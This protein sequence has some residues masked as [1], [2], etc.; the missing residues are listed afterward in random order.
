MEWVSSCWKRNDT[1]AFLLKNTLALWF[2]IAALFAGQP[3]AAQNPAADFHF[4]N[5]TTLQGLSSNDITCLYQDRK[6]FLWVGTHFGL[7]RYD[8]NLFKTFY[9]EVDNSNSLSGNDVS[10]ILEDRD[11]IFWI[12]TKDGGLTRYDPSANPGKQFMQFQNN[13]R[14]A[15]SLAVNRLT[16]LCDYSE[17]YL[18]IGAETVPAIF[19]NKKTFGLTYAP[20]S[21]IE[22]GY[23]NPSH[24]RENPS[25]PIN[26]IHHIESTDSSIYI[27]FLIGGYVY[28]I[29][30]A[31]GKFNIPAVVFKASPAFSIP[32]FLVDGQKIWLAA[33]RKG[34]FVQDGPLSDTLHIPVQRK[35]MNVEDEILCLADW[36]SEYVVAGSKSSGLYLV[37]RQDY[38]LVNLHHERSDLF[39]IASNRVNCLLRD[40][41]GILWV[42]TSDGLSKYDPEQWQLHSQ[43]LLPDDGKDLVHFSMYEDESGTLRLCSS[44]GVF[45]FR[46]GEEVPELIPFEEKGED[47]SPA[48]IF[49]SDNGTYYLGSETRMF[50][51][52]PGS[53]SISPIE[54]K[55]LDG[56]PPGGY[57][58]IN[59]QVRSILSDT[60]DGHPFLI[61]GILGDGLGLYDLEQKQ[62]KLMVKSEVNP[63]SIGN[64]LI[65]A[66]T[67]DHDGTIWVGT[68]NGL[69]RWRKSFPLQNDFDSFLHEPGND[70]TI[71]GNE[72]T[73]LWVD[74]QNHLWITTNGNGLNEFDGTIFRHYHTTSIMGNKMSDLVEDGQ[75]RLWIA[76]SSGFAVFTKE[77]K[78]FDEIPL[79]NSEWILK[80]PARMLRRKDGTVVYGAGNYLISFRPDS[81]RISHAR[82]QIYLTGFTVMGQEM[83]AESP[84]Q[85]LTFPFNRNF[86]TFRFSA[87]Q[88]SQP[89]TV[90][91]QYWLKGLEDNWVDAA[92]NGQVAFTSLPPGTFD[93]F[94][95]ATDPTGSWGPP[96]SLATFRIMTP[97]WLTWWFI[98][99]CVIA[100][101]ALVLIITRIRVQQLLRLQT[102][103]QKIAADL[104]DDIGSA[105]SSISISSQLVKKF[106]THEDEKVDRILNRIN[107]TSKETLESMSDIVWAINPKNDGGGSMMMK[108]QRVAADLLESKGIEVEFRCDREFE[109]MKLGMEARKNIFLIYKEAIN[110]ISRHSGCSKVCIR[111]HV[112]DQHFHL[113][114]EDDG[115]GFVFTKSALGNGLDSMQRRAAML[116]ESLVI[117]SEVGRGT[118]IELKIPSTKIRD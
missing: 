6:G 59:L 63:G 56:A 71:S 94:V 29:D 69:Y 18:L 36:S 41:Q 85:E 45:R 49:R 92:T 87:L 117:H 38:S 114:L 103:R 118:R 42:G 77:T 74:N 79:A 80:A 78:K 20:V 35:V 46:R 81:F 110:N 37:N 115:K 28:S 31:T 97:F 105:L 39:S 44:A 15:G 8:G 14:K 112:S 109:R 10:D 89:A 19:L 53:E 90:R 51:Y 62:L 72:I 52:A 43:T 65:R 1:S 23:L 27:T 32:S 5:I 95:R 48:C 100:A 61:L 64:N 11:G 107:T 21:R 68:S 30:R 7:N 73:G 82:P 83:R 40:K 4:E 13:P 111:I 104:H 26:W 16:C 108:M 67:R 76:T 25:G 84:Q 101:A 60:V 70:S 102:V 58:M 93:F 88:L 9:H 113:L 96:V 3:A 99:S 116:G 47:I 86:V 55:S 17:D 12:A 50:R 2:M 33:W 75:H 24:S 91:Y 57:F 66:L 22:D 54:L 106:S 34:L 98:L